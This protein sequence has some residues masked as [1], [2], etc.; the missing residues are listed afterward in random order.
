M[1]ILFYDTETTGL[2]D[3]KGSMRDVSQPHIIQLA[4]IL[5]DDDGKIMTQFCSMV[6]LPQGAEV[7]EIAFNTHGISK[8]M[9]E[10]YGLSIVSVLRLLER[11]ISKAD[12]VVGHNIKFDDWMIEREAAVAGDTGFVFTKPRECTQAMASPICKI[13]PTEK[14]IAAGFTK[15]KPPKLEEAYRL[16]I[17]EEM[18]GAHDAMG[19]CLACMRVFFAI[20][21]AQNANS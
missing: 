21:K 12:L 17:G 16:I 15:P 10:K 1:P 4:A 2:P 7:G 6:Q 14:M 18:S 11:L 5:T 9:A 19:D 13:P 8:E 20:R 3:F